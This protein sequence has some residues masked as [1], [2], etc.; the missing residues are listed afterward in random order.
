MPLCHLIDF[1]KEKTELHFPSSFFTFNFIKHAL[2]LVK[3]R[4]GWKYTINKENAI[5]VPLLTL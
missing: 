2:R 5:E 1:S 3:I 4:Q